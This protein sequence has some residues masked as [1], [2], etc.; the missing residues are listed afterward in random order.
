MSWMSEFLDDC[1]DRIGKFEEVKTELGIAASALRVMIS[2]KNE[3]WLD[4][5]VP[6][7]YQ[8]DKDVIQDVIEVLEKVQSM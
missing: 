5:G 6:F 4:G 8:K 1:E 7:F 2:Q 3:V